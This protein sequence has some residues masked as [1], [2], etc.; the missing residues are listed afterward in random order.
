[1]MKR[2]D[3]KDGK[4]PRA[5]ATQAAEEADFQ[6]LIRQ[7]QAGDR[8]AQ[9]RLFERY[10]DRLQRQAERRLG[11]QV[12]GGMNASDVVQETL[13][14]AADGLPTLAEPSRPV[15]ESWLS[16]ILRNTLVQ[17]LRGVLRKKRDAGRA[18]P[19]QDLS[20]QELAAPQST[21][22]QVV[23][24]AQEWQR[25]LQA[26]GRLP[27]AQREAV[28]LRHVEG[29]SLQEI[30]TRLGRTELAAA[31]L[32][33]RGMATLRT[34]LGEEAERLGELQAAVKPEGR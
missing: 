10:R 20:A 24:S 23:A 33:R 2:M 11:Q 25:A 18:V 21:P 26:L 31:S 30:A 5:D 16:R 9:S 3:G 17:G 7:A 1:M 15:L 32:L 4:D 28:W 12:V 6:R 22:S 19:L 14:R 13:L 34:E 8:A 29:L 27:E